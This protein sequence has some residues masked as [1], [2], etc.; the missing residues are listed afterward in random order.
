MP[1][2]GIPGGDPRG[3]QQDLADRLAVDASSFRLVHG[4][5]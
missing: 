3:E 5:P 1:V 2:A 4:L